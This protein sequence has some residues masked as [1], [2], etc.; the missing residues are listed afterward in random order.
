MKTIL[1]IFSFLLIIHYSE[2]QV[3]V[4]QKWTKVFKSEKQYSNPYAD[5]TVK[6]EFS[7]PDNLKYI[8]NGYWTGDSNYAISFSFPKPG[9]W[10]WKTICNDEGNGGLHLQSG[11]VKVKKYR[12]KNPLYRNG[13]LK[14]GEN[15]RYLA[16]DNDKPFLWM[17]CTAWNGAVASTM[18]EWEEYINDR[19]KKHF[20]I[21]QVTPFRK[22]WQQDGSLKRVV[23]A[24]ETKAE[25]NK[26]GDEPFSGY[27]DKI[28][29]AYWADFAQKVEYANKNGLVVV[30]VGLPGWQFYFD[31]PGEQKT[32]AQ[33]LTGLLAGNFVIFSPSSDRPYSIKSDVMAMVIDSMDSRHLI[34][35]HPGT[36]P[37]G[38]VSVIAQAYYD[39]P[40]LDFSMCQSGH[41]G[42][43]RDKCAH[44]AIY[45]NLSLYNRESHKPVINGE[46]FYHGGNRNATEEKYRG[47]DTDARSLGWL[48]W[49]SGSLGYTYGALGIWNWGLT[50][51]G[52]YVPWRD[53]IQLN[54]SFQMKYMSEFFSKINWWELGPFS[55]AIVNQSQDTI[56]QM[57]FAKNEEGTLAVAY[58]PDNRNVEIDMDVFK[59]SVKAKWFNPRNNQ[60]LFIHGELENRGLYSFDTPVSDP[61][62]WVLLMQCK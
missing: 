43:R 56:T 44:N 12:G 3:Q 17:G 37:Q 24:T 35:Q 23:N 22:E 21:I 46:A 13:F 54:S 38:T 6:A 33:Y 5:L 30:L 41:N 25:K 20:T 16:F 31:N 4:W 42:G 45:W 34:T 15:K 40:Y 55:Q 58:L 10:T 53:A 59:S 39:K 19:T 52:V 29:P 26:L 57:V 18:D 1:L 28:N 51:A 2:A 49:L 62:D 14:V 50:T 48:S 60:F 47:T 7:G 32:F 61:G 27:F 8:V 36:G 9:N 11:E